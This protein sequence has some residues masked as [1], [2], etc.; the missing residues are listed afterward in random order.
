MFENQALNEAIVQL[1]VAIVGFVAALVV[2]VGPIVRKRVELWAHEKYIELDRLTP[3]YLDT[4]I[5]KAAEIAVIVVEATNL[6]GESK[7]KLKQAEEI[8]EKWLMDVYGYE[9]ELDRIREAIEFVLFELKQDE[10][11]VEVDLSSPDE[12][13]LTRH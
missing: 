9:I 11:T 5:K 6:K 3:D 1:L 10:R 13:V 7:E 12:T 8:A 4:I 2:V